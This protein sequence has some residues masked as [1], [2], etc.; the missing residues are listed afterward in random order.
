MSVVFDTY[1][2]IEYFL[3]SEKGKIVESYLKEKPITPFIVLLEL[4]YRADKEGW[5]FKKYLDF[6]KLN[7]KVTGLTEDFI[8]DFGS[9][10]NKTKRKIPKI[11]MADIIILMT[12]VKENAS[13]LTGDS[14][15]KD[16]KDV[17]FIG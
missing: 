10:Y 6:I 4:S 17:I 14:H 7:S 2:W 9:L 1:A 3:G 11:G 13:I 16:L 12:S 8:L 5:D 15:F